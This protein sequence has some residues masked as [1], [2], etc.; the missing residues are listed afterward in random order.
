[1]H[2]LIRNANLFGISVKGEAL[3][4]AEG[5]VVVS[6][7]EP[8]TADIEIDARGAFVLPTEVNPLAGITAP[9]EPFAQS[10]VIMGGEV[11]RQS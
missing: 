2:L 7:A 8:S 10:R 6:Q 11:I 4:V 5:S 9:A 3:R 1:M